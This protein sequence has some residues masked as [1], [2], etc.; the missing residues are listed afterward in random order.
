MCANRAVLKN[1]KRSEWVL[2]FAINEGVLSN[3]SHPPEGNHH[4]ATPLRR[5]RHPATPPVPCHFPI[6]LT[7]FLTIFLTMSLRPES[8]LPFDRSEWFNLARERLRWGAATRVHKDCGHQFCDLTQPRCCACMDHRPQRTRYYK[9]VDG[10]GMVANAKRWSDYCPGCKLHYCVEEEEEDA[11]SQAQ[12]TSST[13]RETVQTRCITCGELGHA[14]WDCP[15]ILN[16]DVPLLARTGDNSAN[17]LEPTNPQTTTPTMPTVMEQ[18]SAAPQPIDSPR[19]PFRWSSFL[20]HGR[21]SHNI[22][23]SSPPLPQNEREPRLLS[24]PRPM[25]RLVSHQARRERIRANFERSFGTMSDIANDPNY[26]SPIASLYGNAY[27]R[28]QERERERERSRQEFENSRPEEVPLPS[29][30]PREWRTYTSPRRVLSPRRSNQ[31]PESIRRQLEADTHVVLEQLRRQLAEDD[32]QLLENSLET[33]TRPE[34]SEPQ[35]SAA[36]LGLPSIFGQWYNRDRDTPAFSPRFR[37]PSYNP[38]RPKTPEPLGKEDLMISNECKICFSQHCDT[39]LLP[40]AHLALCEVLL[41][42]VEVG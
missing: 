40:C 37:E 20:N 2:S 39:L 30:P 15:R 26:V 38:P 7:V 19:V 23:P 13:Q 25:P 31:S 3:H 10:Q 16:E 17:T 21:T 5:I 29:S 6:L 14:I 28:L 33:T 1:M 4:H 12:A 8:H 42:L 41:V 32:R 18:P 24:P 11:T 9:Y 22:P 27:A 34:E 35:P 36:E